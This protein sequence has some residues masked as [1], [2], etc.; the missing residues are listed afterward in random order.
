MI[1][2]RQFSQAALTG[3]VAPALSLR[4][5]GAAPVAGVRLGVQTYSFRELTRQGTAEALD[6]V[7]ASM[8]TCGVD[9]CELWSPQIELAPPAG[10]DA[11]ASAGYFQ[12]VGTPFAHAGINFY[13]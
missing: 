12:G 4:W 13:A 10:R 2:R 1:T 6:V 3:L 7:L 11:P 5:A 8:K 9:E